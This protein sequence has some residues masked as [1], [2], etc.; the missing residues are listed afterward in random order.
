MNRAALSLAWL[1]LAGLLAWPQAASADI[2]NPKPAAGDLVLPMPGGASMAFRPV[3]IGEGAEPFAL[4]KVRVGDPGGGFKEHPTTVV[5]GGSFREQVAGAKEWIY[6]LA[7]YEVSQAQYYAIMDPPAGADAA[8]LKKSAKPITGISWFDAVEFLNRYN[9]WLYANAKDKLPTNE[10][11]VGFLRLPNEIEWEFA[12]RGGAAVQPDQFDRQHPYTGQLSRYEWFFSPASSHGKLKNTGVLA[13]NPLGLHDML[14][15]VSEM[16][17]APYQIEYYQG[18]L[19]GVVCRGGNYLTPAKRIRS[20]YR[21]E[22]AFYNNKLQPATQPTLGFR[23]VISSVIYANLRTSRE[24]ES[25]WEGYRAT[26]GASLPAAVSVSPTSTQTNVKLATSLEILQRLQTSLNAPGAP[27]EAKRQ[28]QLLAASF[29]DIESLINKAE[30][31]AAYSWV[32]QA[33]V[34]GLMISRQ[35]KKVPASQDILNKALSMDS[36]GPAKKE[37]FRQRHQNLLNDIERLLPVYTDTVRELDKIKKAAVDNA[38]G[39]YRTFLIRQNFAEAM[40]VMELVI[41]HYTE[42][43]RTK[44]AG[45]DKWKSDLG[46]L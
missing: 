21:T 35:L 30:E 22:L 14:G 18:R 34:N 44:R 9:L 11:A 1:L 10:G 26:S 33:V 31:D 28:A 12:A 5:V 40:R 38:F 27:E 13:P 6:Y 46:Q 19:G 16:T 15:N 39:K 37:Q 29:S 45:S 3:A 20:S 4:K 41:K 42:Y 36:W 25:A 24:L 8:K 7:K 23:P 43:N 32:K 2:Y 17:I